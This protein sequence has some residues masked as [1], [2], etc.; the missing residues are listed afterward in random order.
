MVHKRLLRVR[1][2]CDKRGW[3]SKTTPYNQIRE[4]LFPPPIRDGAINVWPEHEV[5]AVIDYVIAGRSEDDM[6]ALVRDLVAQRSQ[7][8]AA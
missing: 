7:A 1:A 3:K 8:V 6:R 5:D 4:G 2:V